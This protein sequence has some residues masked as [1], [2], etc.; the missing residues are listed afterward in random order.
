[1]QVLIAGAIVA[2]ACLTAQAQETQSKELRGLPPRPTPGE[3]QTQA[4]AGAVTIAAE[5]VGHSVPTS[6]GNL[7]TEDYVIVETGVFGGTDAHLIL[8]I[9]DFSLRINGKKTP[10]VAQPFGA[11]FT[12][13]KDPEY[14]PPEPPA[15]SGKSKTSLSSGGGGGGQGD[16]PPP[17][18]K[19]QIPMEMRR[20][21]QQ[22]VQKA[23]LPEGDRALPVAGLLF[24]PYSGKTQGI[25]SIELLYNGPAGKATLA[26]H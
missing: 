11:I 7:S 4:K 19:I 16:P 22:R 25:R 17:P 18:P 23:A 26:L 24:F 9:Q 1:M 21:M 2:A 14:E 8:S 20:A 3:Y 10:L 15:S 6:Q 5:F 12:S 13:L